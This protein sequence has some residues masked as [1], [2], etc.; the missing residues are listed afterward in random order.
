MAAQL[1]WVSAPLLAAAADRGLPAADPVA[2]G[3]SVDAMPLDFTCVIC[4]H[5]S[6]RLFEVSGY[7]I[8]R[9][10]SCGH[11]FA[12]LGSATN[13]VERQYGDQY[14]TGGGAGYSNYLRDERLL[15]ARGRWYA[16][17]IAAYC[18]P[19][20]VCDVG[21]AAGFTLVG[22]HEA[23]WTAHGIEP[24]P[25]MAQYARQRFE[26]HVETGSFEDW[27]TESTSDLVTMLQVLPH[28]IDPDR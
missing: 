11:Q 16:N 7:W 2:G 17:C 21:A 20:T 26:V 15:I 10:E 25:R 3:P 18:Q 27:Q 9:C 23:G 1:F 5:D 22:F 13:H 6:E 14:F 8:R 4:R 24:N 12:E 28:F 19:G